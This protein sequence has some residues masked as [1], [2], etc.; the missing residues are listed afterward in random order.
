MRLTVGE[1]KP[2]LFSM[3]RSRACTNSP[4]AKKC[5]CSW[6][7]M[8]VILL[9][10]CTFY[11]GIQLVS[12]SQP[13]VAGDTSG[14]RHDIPIQ[15]HDDRRLHDYFQDN[16]TLQIVCLLCGISLLFLSFLGYLGFWRHRTISAM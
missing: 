3:G 8:S 5:R 4:G 14:I 2:G 12:I 15:R 13:S 7:D 16:T 10:T 6:L 1:K 9:F 11:I